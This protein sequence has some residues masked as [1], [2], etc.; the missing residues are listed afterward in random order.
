MGHRV[1]H[2]RKQRIIF[3]WKEDIYSP[4]RLMKNGNMIL[5]VSLVSTAA[6][7]VLGVFRHLIPSH[8][9]LFGFFF[10]YIVMLPGYL[11]TLR[12]APWT[13]GTLRVLTTFIFGTAISFAVLFIAALFRLDIRIIG[14]LTPVIVIALA[15]WGKF[16][17][18]VSAASASDEYA[19]IPRDGR[20][21]TT[22][23]T[24]LIVAVSLMILLIGDPLTY[25]SDS[26]DHI[27]YIRTVS[28]THEAFPDQ[29]YY[30]DGGILTHDIRKGVGQALW[31][32]LNALTGRRDAAPVWP[33]M[34][35][36]GSIFMLLALFCA[37]LVLFR[38]ASIGLIASI[39]FVLFSTGGLRG[40]ELVMGG[41]GYAFGKIFYVAALAFLPL[42]LMSSKSRYLLPAAVASFAA[43][44]AHIAHFVV[45]LF[46]A[47]VFILSNLAA[48]SGTDRRNRFRRGLFVVATIILI[49][50]PYLA[51]RYI[52]DYAPGN[53]L[54]TH[55]QG[56]LFLTEKLYVFNPL[57]FARVAGP[58]GILSFCALF[59]LWKRSRT[60][61]HLRLLL[62]GL[63]AVYVLLFN[64]LWFPFLFKRMTY[65]LTRLEFAVPSMIVCAYLLRELWIKLRRRNAEL[66]T[67]GAIIG[68]VAAAAILIFPLVKTTSELAR[69]GW[70]A[71]GIADA[72]YRSLTDLFGFMEKECPPGSVIASDP[73]TSFG[74][75]AFTDQYVICPYDQHST[76]NDSTAVERIRDCG[77]IFNPGISISGIRDI[78]VKYGAGYLVVNGRIP[79]YIETMYWKP[80]RARAK[81]LSERLRDSTGLFS[82]VFDRA[83]ITVA[84]LMARPTHG[85]SEHEAARLPFLGDSIDAGTADRLPA[86]GIPA[87]RIKGVRASRTEA[88]RGDTISVAI[89]WVATEECPFSSYIA[90]L[91]FDTDFP[92]RAFYRESFG[93]PYRKLLEK[94][95]GHRFRFRVD[96]QPLGGVAPPD[97]WPLMHE[98]RDTVY[99]SI[100]RDIAPGTYTISCKLAEKPQFPNYVLKD[101]LTDDDFYRGAAAAAVWV[102]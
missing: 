50:A 2:F 42:S 77:R 11:T 53:P 70:T 3:N 33:L 55:V 1:L 87:I 27:A 52:R 38:S 16:R 69:G 79:P 20:L 63:I 4:A 61:E 30:H 96:F 88:A 68:A 60:D 91:R 6:F 23:L 44:C 15:L 93:K 17:Q 22:I 81:E 24:I 102:R 95:T 46:I 31:G 99:V 26:A 62:C 72:S 28:R 37:G 43:T 57:E 71:H 78:L 90:Y 65:L 89:T 76:P 100:P 56:V 41:T 54:H 10:L 101:I 19:V 58:L 14:V 32:A 35:L 45:I 13:T 66:S 9:F 8:R 73:I 12:I 75:P 92:K 74:I 48:Q 7:L 83:G 51:L 39:L 59:V 80:D 36:I 47:S 64:P 18:E 98:I 97:T 86:S 5:A 84:Q 25:T 29:F 82:V 34:S 49:N 67:R 85:P 94:Y 21:P 40:D